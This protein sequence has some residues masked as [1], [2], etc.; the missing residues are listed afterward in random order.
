MIKPLDIPVIIMAIVL[1]FLSGS[2]S[3][4][5][6]ASMVVIRG[7]YNTWVYPMDKEELISVNGILGETLI[8]IHNGS[9]AIVSSP[10]TG[11]TCVAAGS[12]HKNGQ[13]T[14]CLPNRVFLLIEGSDE[15]DD[16]DAVAW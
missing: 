13:W 15:K 1:A 12:L 14:S 3:G 6:A 5:S 4:K 11:Q 16:V 9:A 7:P 2:S 10:C 8:A